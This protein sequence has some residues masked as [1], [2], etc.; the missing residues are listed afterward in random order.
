MV[1]FLAIEQYHI[2]WVKLRG[3]SSWPAIVEGQSG[4]QM[5]KVHFFGDYTTSVVT[6]SSFVSSFRDG[7]VEYE[8]SKNS[9]LKLAKA[10]KE[11]SLVFLSN[12]RQTSCRIC[13][14]NLK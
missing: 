10:V 9:N 4:A 7:F 2:Y 14:M 3:Y 6:R 8:K 12:E 1:P 11:A 13:E 5:F